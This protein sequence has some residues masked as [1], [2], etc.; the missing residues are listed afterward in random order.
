MTEWGTFVLLKLIILS[1]TVVAN[2]QNF[3]I[4]NLFIESVVKVIQ[5]YFFYNF[6]FELI[7]DLGKNCLFNLIR[8]FINYFNLKNLIFHNSYFNYLGLNSK[9]HF[10]STCLIYQKFV[11]IIIDFN[12]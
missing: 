3:I 10:N 8:I 11:L 5:Y 2:S 9:G 4:F 6:Y 7:R 12:N 1:L